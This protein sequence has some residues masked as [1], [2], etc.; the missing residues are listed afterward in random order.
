MATSTPRP[1]RRESALE[2][3]LREGVEASRSAVHLVVA[4][5]DSGA[6]FPRESAAHFRRR[7][8]IPGVI[9]R[10]I[11]WGTRPPILPY[12]RPLFLSLEGTFPACQ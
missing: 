10:V 11:H 4:G 1:Q 3:R 6:V 7:I 9:P 2:A 5:V 12:F 8:D